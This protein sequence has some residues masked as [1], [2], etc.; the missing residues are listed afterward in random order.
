MRDLQIP[1]LGVSDPPHLA[2]LFWSSP[3]HL[4]ASRAHHSLA[5]APSPRVVP[6]FYLLPQQGLGGPVR[7]ESAC[8]LQEASETKLPA[9]LGASGPLI[10]RGCCF[11]G[12]PQQSP[13]PPLPA[14]PQA[15]FSGESYDRQV[16]KTGAA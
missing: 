16:N 3:Q 1:T 8:R 12:D 4:L 10:G 15:L 5:D 13:R 14:P 11:H 6:R 9:A 2:L 7:Q